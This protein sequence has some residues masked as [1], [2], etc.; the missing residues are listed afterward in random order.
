MLRVILIGP[1]V[2]HFTAS[3]V[4]SFQRQASQLMMFYVWFKCSDASP[5][6]FVC[7]VHFHCFTILTIWLRAL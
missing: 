6:V 7:K 3:F 2:F 1:F 5:R 4:E